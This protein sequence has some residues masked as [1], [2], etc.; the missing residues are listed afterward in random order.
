[1]L[2]NSSV[3]ERLAAS[4]EGLGPMELVTAV[5]YTGLLTERYGGFGT[6]RSEFDG[7]PKPVF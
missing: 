6:K 3:G 4:Q 5:L 2:G 7:I 1:M